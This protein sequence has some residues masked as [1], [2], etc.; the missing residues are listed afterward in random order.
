MEVWKA[1]VEGGGLET[2][3]LFLAAINTLSA[4]GVQRR[5]RMRRQPRGTPYNESVHNEV[6]CVRKAAELFDEYMENVLEAEEGLDLHTDM[7]ASIASKMKHKREMLNVAAA[8]LISAHV[9]LGEFD[10]V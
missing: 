7:P 6:D 1:H 8:S 4:A 5:D 9:T 10:K 2:S 3:E